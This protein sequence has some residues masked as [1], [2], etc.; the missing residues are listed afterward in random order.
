MRYTELKNGKEVEISESEF[1]A[2]CTDILKEYK[3]RKKDEML[4]PWLQYPEY[5]IDS[6]GWRM[7]LSESYMV[8]W[9]KYLNS[10]S[11]SDKLLYANKYPAK[12]GF[13]KFYASN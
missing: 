2:F 4:P 12:Q 13:E 11:I 8:D 5:S 1:K 6:M 3:S 7:G 9:R 10:L